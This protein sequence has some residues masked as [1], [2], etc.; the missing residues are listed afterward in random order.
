MK[1][2]EGMAERKDN[3]YG[4]QMSKERR[5]KRQRKQKEEEEYIDG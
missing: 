5:G 4:I 3:T 2:K 1:S